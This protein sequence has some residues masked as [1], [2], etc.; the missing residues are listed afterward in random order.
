ML[1]LHFFLSPAFATSD[2]IRCFTDHAKSFAEIEQEN[3]ASLISPPGEP[4]HSSYA[5]EFKD[6]LNGR[7]EGG[8]YSSA[9]TIVSLSD[10]SV[11]LDTFSVT[12]ETLAYRYPHAKVIKTDIRFSN[13][14]QPHK[15]GGVIADIPRN[16][17]R[18]AHLKNIIWKE[19]A[20]RVAKE[21]P[22][23][24]VVLFDDDSYDPPR[25]KGIK[26]TARPKPAPSRIRLGIKQPS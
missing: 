7:D 18:R 4:A 13:T 26:I 11:T 16:N 8:I 9:K 1:I 17:P 14:G 10:G 19:A 21:N 15:D 5:F 24:Q 20:T 25:F 2:Q 23:L 6:V 12:G 22:D 3:K